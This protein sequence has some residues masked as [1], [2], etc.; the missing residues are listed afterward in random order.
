MA[1]Q[2]V[3]TDPKAVA[4]VLW[5]VDFACSRGLPELVQSKLI[6]TFSFDIPCFF[7][8]VEQETLVSSARFVV[9]RIINQKST[10]CLQAYPL[11]QE[12]VSQLRTQTF[13]TALNDIA[14]SKDVSKTA[15]AIALLEGVIPSVRVHIQHVW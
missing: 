1:Q 12:L 7:E 2:Q 14:N 4:S 5:F 15:D 11:Q 13:V 8:H 10:E 9:E 6:F 3:V